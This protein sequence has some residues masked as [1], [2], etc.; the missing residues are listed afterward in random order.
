MKSKFVVFMVMVIFNAFSQHYT[1]PNTT[2]FYISFK[3]TSLENLQNEEIVQLN[4]VIQQY[5]FTFEKA[6]AITPEKIEY[7]KNEALKNV[8]NTKAVDALQRIVVLQIKEILTYEKK[9]KLVTELTQLPFIDQIQLKQ[10]K[11]V[12]PP[13]D[14]PPTTPNLIASQ[15]YIQANPGVNM[16]Y[17]WDNG[18]TGSGINIRD[19]EYGMNDN[20]EEFNAIN[21]SIATGMTVNSGA[22]AAYTEHGTAAIGIMFADNGIYGVSGLAYGANEAVLYPEWTNENGYNRVYAVS[23]AISNSS[24]GDVI[25]YEMQAYGVSGGSAND[26]VPAEYDFPIWQLTKAATDAGIIVVAAAGNGNQNLDSASYTTYMNYGD[27]GAILVGA[28]TSNTTHSRLNYSTYG[29][30]INVQG[31]GQNVLAPGYGDAYIFGS[32][33][34][35]QYT[36]FSGTSSATPIVA[37]CAVVLQA[38]HYATNGSYL[39]SQQIR[40]LL[41]QTGIPQGGDTTKNIGPL[42]NMQAAITLLLNNLT[43]KN[44]NDVTLTIFP[45]PATNSIF[46]QSYDESYIGSTIIIYNT[47]GQNVLQSKLDS[48]ETQLDISKLQSGLY[49]VEINNLSKKTNLKFIKQ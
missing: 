10:H 31:W 29:S 39:T 8:G 45:N 38:I 37:S 17:A 49:W 22:T 35:Q 28:G 41:V 46:I 48:K 26:F 7:L 47:L 23:Q 9:E 34:N 16:Q 19:I 18:Y 43:T 6:I 14:I 33:F 24:A 11:V 30:R 1:V 5:D 13:T 4:N 36:Y 32:D 20:H 42:P 21:T 3:N 12:P 27:S 25:M 40:D 44:F 15:T 2:S